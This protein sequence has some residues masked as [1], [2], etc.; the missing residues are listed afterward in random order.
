MTQCFIDFLKEQDV[1]FIEDLD[2]K[3]ISSIGIGGRAKLAV[4]PNSEEKLLKTVSFLTQLGEGYKVVGN[5][6][7]ILFPDTDF[8]DVLILT[9]NVNGYRIENDMFYAECGGTFSALIRKIADLGYCGFDE[10][11]GIPGSVGGMVFGNAGAYGKAMSD[12]TVSVRIYSPIADKITEIPLEQMVFSYRSSALKHSGEIVL[13]ALFR[14]ERDSAEKIRARLLSIVERRKRA[15]PSGKSLGSI[16]KRHGNLPVSRLIDELG[17]KGLTV[18]GAVISNKH[19]GFIMNASEA[20]A[21]DV[22]ALISE[23]KRGVYSQYGFIPEEE[24]EIL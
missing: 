5:T 9:R 20:S 19:A 4:L 13:S 16:F 22:R 6:T 3:Q 2:I 18:G 17:M 23:V 11:Y 8:R 15:Q 14:T 1:K 21:A 24:I 12:V 10:L 7:N